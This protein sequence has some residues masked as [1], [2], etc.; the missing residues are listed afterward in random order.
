MENDVLITEENMTECLDQD[1]VGLKAL[2]ECDEFNIDT[3]PESLEIEKKS[4]WKTC[5]CGNIV[6][7]SPVNQFRC[8]NCGNIQYKNNQR[9]R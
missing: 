6:F 7:E 5:K 4:E 1:L 9:E 2:L 8:G 3:T